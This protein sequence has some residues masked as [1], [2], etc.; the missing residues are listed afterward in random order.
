MSRMETVEEGDA[1]LL[2]T[3]GLWEPI[4]ESEMLEIVRSNP[5][6]EACAKM[7]QLGLDRQATD[8]LSVQ[9]IKVVAVEEETAEE[10]AQAVPWW[11]KL[12][13]RNGAHPTE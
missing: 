5:P 9:V 10:A 11:R 4:H 6:P 3:D 2:C 12:F 1:F 7:V 13:G 8:N